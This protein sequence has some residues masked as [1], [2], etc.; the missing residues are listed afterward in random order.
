[1]ELVVRDATGPHGGAGVLAGGLHRTVVVVAD[2]G[3]E[4]ESLRRVFGRAFA[5]AGLDEAE[6]ARRFVVVAEEDSALARDAREA[7]HLFVPAEPDVDWRFVARRARALVAA[8]LA[9]VGGEAV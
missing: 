1:A 7:G 9:G 8:P 2:G 5:E 3:A 4:A 6:S